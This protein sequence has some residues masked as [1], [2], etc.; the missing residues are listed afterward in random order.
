M[1]FN[2]QLNITEQA[3]RDLNAISYSLI[4]KFFRNG[5][6]SLIV[7]ETVTASMI[8]GSLV[9]CLLTEPDEFDETY[10]V[11]DYSAPSQV[12]MDI[13]QM[14]KNQC[15]TATKLSEVSDEILLTCAHVY[16][17]YPTYKDVTKLKYIREGGSEHF[18]MLG[19]T[20]QVVS[21]SDYQAAKQVVETLVSHKFTAKYFN[22]DPFNN[23]IQS[24][25]QAK[26][27]ISIKIPMSDGN[28][29][30][31]S[32]K[33]MFDRLLIDHTNETIQPIDLKTTGKPEEAFKESFEYWCY[34]VQASLYTFILRQ[35]CNNHEQ[36]K[37]YKIL[38]FKFVVINR[39]SQSPIVWNFDVEQ[40][41]ID[42][43]SG[44]Y[45]NL[46]NWRVMIPAILYHQQTEVYNYSYETIK[47]QGENQLVL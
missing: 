35:L 4:S 31:A 14:A 32:L 18:E 40:F 41:D 28:L 25:N 19:N 20:K 12:I 29:T 46:C 8:F 39:F 22:E 36:F 5:P 37:S 45:P 38:P 26:F 16:K 6:S 42:I 33:C 44:K 24:M 23:A 10:I 11:K 30:T 21:Q 2:L 47:N 15:P 3:Y 13:L 1:K 43:K 34:Y 7:D 27:G 17:Y 9:D